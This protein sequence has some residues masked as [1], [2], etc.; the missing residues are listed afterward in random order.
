LSG[1]NSF[2]R[3]PLAGLAAGTALGLTDWISSGV[4][5]TPAPLVVACLLGGAL[6]GL[7]AGLVALALGR[8]RLTLALLLGGAVALEGL[9]A[10]SKHLTGGNQALG[11]VLAVAFA[12]ATVVVIGRE[13]A[14]DPPL[15]ALGLVASLPAGTWLGGTLSRDPWMLVASCAVP[16][17]WIAVMRLG[18][19]RPRTLVLGWTGLLAI[20]GM[21]QG[22]PAPPQRHLPDA[23][24]HPGA[25][26]PS[27]VLLVIDTLRADAL[28]PGG[29]LE[30]FGR[31]GVTFRR[32]ESVAPW[33]LPAVSSLLTGL[34]PSQHGAV[35]AVTPLADEVTTLAEVLHDHGYATAAFTGGA[36][37]GSAHRLDQGFE[38]FDSTRERRFEPFGT[39]VPLAWRLA[40]N[41]FFPLHW[42][43]RAVDESLG[44]EGI[45]QA[46]EEWAAGPE[47]RPRF[48]LLHT[49]QVHDY[50]IYDPNLDDEVLATLPEASDAFDGR[51][52]VRPTELTRASQEDLDHFRALYQGRVRSVDALFPSLRAALA[53][54]LG[55]DAIW[56][57]TA[58]HGEGFD[59]ERGRV[60]HGGRLHEALLHAP[61]LLQ[62]PGRLEEGRQVEE[63]VRSVDVLPTVLELVGIPVPE[64][65]AGQ[66]LVPALRGSGAFPG[67]SFAEERAH[68]YDLISVQQE[69]W[70]WIRAPGHQELFHLEEDPGEIRP[71][72]GPP[73]PAVDAEMEAFPRRYPARALGEIRLDPTTLE[74][75]QAL[76][77]V[78]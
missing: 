11:A 13:K 9:S 51:L 70:K 18:K 6:A 4:S 41:R 42:L 75:L 20:L 38:V 23:A 10:A 47:S 45:A 1:P 50:Y 14:L 28:E 15:V 16:L 76:G 60:H 67:S 66:S 68:G 27:I 55:A 32:C 65:L 58:D 5:S 64:G 72:P 8:P 39:R 49:Y 37:V 33:T 56:I 29:S 78:R 31:G 53:P 57:V 3:A 52:S 63:M 25:T 36:F 2:H 7:L 54:H 21:A 74:H 22:E 62:A 24:T 61:L 40:K 19:S 46:A 12:L 48:L 26:G 43:V 17:V 69:G 71:L 73:P 35:T 59:A 77:Y 30:A 44:M 34:Y